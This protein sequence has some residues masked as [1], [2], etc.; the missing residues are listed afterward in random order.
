MVLQ[1]ET[2]VLRCL[3][4]AVH[5]APT[6]LAASQFPDTWEP[7]SSGNT[8]LFEVD[9][10]SSEVQHLVQPMLQTGATVFKV[11]P[12]CICQAQPDCLGLMLPSQFLHCRI[13]VVVLAFGLY[14][15]R[16]L[17][18]CYH[19]SIT[20]AVSSLL[21]TLSALLAVTQETS[22]NCPP[23]VT[24][25]GAAWTQICSRSAACVIVLLLFHTSGCA[26][27]LHPV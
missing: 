13:P 22:V 11:N 23:Q 24:T 17:L 15:C 26:H 16:L 18:Q 6:S 27:M 25:I 5:Q 9:L 2:H 20:V 8:E 4:T 10:R 14:H 19:C 21:H 1:A 3:Y 7:Q 12:C